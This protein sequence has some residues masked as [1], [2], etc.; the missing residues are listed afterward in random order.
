MHQ[1]YPHH[2]LNQEFVTLLVEDIT[3]FRLARSCV[4]SASNSFTRALASSRYFSCAKFSRVSRKPRYTTEPRRATGII[5]GSR[6]EYHCACA[7]LLE[8]ANSVYVRQFFGVDAAR[9]NW[10]VERSIV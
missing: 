9:T 4:T 1:S 10:Q 7:D 2:H 6:S 8:E 3:L 5:L